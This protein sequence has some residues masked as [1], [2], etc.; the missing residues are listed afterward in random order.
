MLLLGPL[1]IVL[2]FIFG[3]QFLLAFWPFALI[4]LAVV[5]IYKLTRKSPHRSE[6]PPYGR[7]DRL[8]PS[9]THKE[10]RCP[11]SRRTRKSLVGKSAENYEW[12]ERERECRDWL[13]DLRQAWWQLQQAETARPS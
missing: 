1:I 13:R 2:A 6:R 10:A 11:V 4:L 7:S 8:S 5:F 3:V 9:T 12:R